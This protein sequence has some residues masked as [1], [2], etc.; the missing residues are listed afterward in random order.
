V[1]RNAIGRVGLSV[2]GLALLAALLLS[3][4]QPPA[5]PDITAPLLALGGV[6]ALAIAVLPDAVMEV[7]WLVRGPAER[8]EPAVVTRHYARSAPRIVAPQP[9][10]HVPEPYAGHGSAMESITLDLGDLPDLPD[11]PEE[12]VDLDDLP[13][14]PDWPPEMTTQR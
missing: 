11:W 13:D 12:V 7:V 14:L 9:T 6:L 10:F 8:P 3:F 2:G 1:V 5:W 4:V